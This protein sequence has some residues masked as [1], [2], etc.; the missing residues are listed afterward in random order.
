MSGQVAADGQKTSPSAAREALART[1][2]ARLEPA[3]A[4]ARLPPPPSAKPSGGLRNLSGGVAAVARCG[5][6]RAGPPGSGQ[7]RSGFAAFLGVDAVTSGAGPASADFLGR[8]GRPE[9]TR[10]G[11]KNQGLTVRLP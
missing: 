5:P 1:T 6:L 4:S 10:R 2:T 3:Q 8:A 7:T 9:G 11:A